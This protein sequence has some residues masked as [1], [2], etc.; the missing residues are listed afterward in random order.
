MKYNDIYQKARQI[1]ADYLRVEENEVNL[2]TDLVEDLCADSIALVE[3]GFKFSE[4]FSVPMMDAQPES[5]IVK[6]IVDFLEC[7]M[8]TVKK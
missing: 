2:E 4:V 5:F 1:I 3:L 8:N 7:N 6:N